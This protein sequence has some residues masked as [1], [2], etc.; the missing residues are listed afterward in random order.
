[1]IGAGVALAVGVPAALFSQSPALASPA[2]A[3][4]AATDKVTLKNGTVLEGEIVREVE[5]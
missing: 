4:R 3:V 5:G 1:M 2:V